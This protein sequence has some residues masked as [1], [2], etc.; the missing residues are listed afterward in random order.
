MDTCAVNLA[1]TSPKTRVR[2]LVV[3]DSPFML[4]ILAEIVEEAGDFDL[5]GTATDGCQALR[6]VADL[7]PELVLMDVQMPHL[8]G[9]E[10]T[11][12]MKQRQHPPVVLIVTSD[13]NPETKAMAETAG[14][15]GFFIKPD[16]LRNRLLATLQNLFR[17]RGKRHATAGSASLQKSPS[18]PLTL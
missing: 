5:V 15:D 8:T 7:S 14:A 4:E 1:E 2:T 18:A 11:R 13:D 6:Q 9:I 16:K 3:D 17:P 12:Y 10:A